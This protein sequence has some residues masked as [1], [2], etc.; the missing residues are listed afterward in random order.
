MVLDRL[1]NASQYRGL[2]KRLAAALEFLATTDLNKTPV[3]Q[4]IHILGSEVTGSVSES[5]TKPRDASRQFEAHRRFI[6]VHYVIR[7]TECMGYA[8]L[9]ASKITKP[10]Q[11]ADDYLLLDGPGDFVHVHSGMF[12]IFMP[13]DAHMPGLAA[14]DPQP[15]RKIVIKVAV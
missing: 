6:D 12:V 4:T 10:Y 8:N 1:E 14:G 2:G 11:D 7:G 5:S 3:G 9:D 13:Q 15:L